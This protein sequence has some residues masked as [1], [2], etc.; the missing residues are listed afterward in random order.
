M[1]KAAEQMATGEKLLTSESDL[2]SNI[3]YQQ[4]TPL[5]TDFLRHCLQRLFVNKGKFSYNDII[6]FM[7]I[8]AASRYAD[9]ILT[10]DNDFKKMMGQF[11]SIKDTSFYQDTLRIS[12]YIS[13]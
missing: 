5:E 6:D 13:K 2:F 1:K 7:N 9:G 3:S 10:C 8:S 4:L 11:E 12:D